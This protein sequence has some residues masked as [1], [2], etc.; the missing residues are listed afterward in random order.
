MAQGASAHVSVLSVASPYPLSC[1]YA[2]VHRHT[3][4]EAPS[5]VTE[6]GT[7]CLFT[8]STARC[9]GL[10]LLLLLLLRNP[11]ANT[12]GPVEEAALPPPALHTASTARNF[13]SSKQGSPHVAV[14]A[15][16]LHWLLPTQAAATTALA[17]AAA[18]EALELHAPQ[19]PSGRP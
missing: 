3:P 12:A 15:A 9:G 4:P 8:T 18:K 10:L 17:L 1:V 6:V 13:H 7:H 14:S 16:T 19:P 11:C 5:T 2:S